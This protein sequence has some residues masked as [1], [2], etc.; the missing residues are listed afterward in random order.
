MQVIYY[1]DYST[2]HTVFTQLYYILVL[3]ILDSSQYG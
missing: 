1:M 3:C 2:T